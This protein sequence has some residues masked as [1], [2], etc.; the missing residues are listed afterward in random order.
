MMARSTRQVLVQTDGGFE[1]KINAASFSPDGRR[2]V[3]A[4]SN[5]ALVWDA[6][7]GKSL[8]ESMR[9]DGKV[10]AAHFSP[11]GRRI[12][13]VSEDKTARLWDAESGKPLGE[14]MRHE[15][16]INAASFSPDGRRIVTASYGSARVWDVA[17]DLE[18]PLPAW[19]P[20]LAEAWGGRLA[21]TRN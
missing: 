9:H 20:D 18:S 2:I 8:G 14:A 1:G 17:V 10:Y 7:S 3:T 5:T 4:S 12:L 6:Q 21:R 15:R 16:K 19:V 13:T 11:D